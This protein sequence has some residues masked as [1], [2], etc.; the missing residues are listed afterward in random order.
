[1][2]RLH[3]QKGFFDRQIAQYFREYFL[4]QLP[5]ADER[6]KLQPVFAEAEDWL[7]WFTHADV[8]GALLGLKV[9][10]LSSKSR[11][12]RPDISISC[13]YLPDGPF[14]WRELPDDAEDV[15]YATAREQL[16][17]P[18][19]LTPRERMRALRLQKMAE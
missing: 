19:D 10:D 16:A 4:P 6:E 8:I 14:E 3:S 15:F 1:V 7:L 13:E 9:P 17:L 18:D 2:R 5:G 11:F 12:A